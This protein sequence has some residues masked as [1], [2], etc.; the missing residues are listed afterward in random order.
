MTIK[1]PAG[2]V[3][4]QEEQ[5]AYKIPLS[6]TSSKHKESSPPRYATRVDMTGALIDSRDNSIH[7]ESSVGSGGDLVL[8][9]EDEN[10]VLRKSRI[11]AIDEEVNQQPSVKKLYDKNTFKT[12]ANSYAP[13][14][15]KKKLLKNFR[16]WN[17]ENKLVLLWVVLM[18]IFFTMSLY[19]RAQSNRNVA[20]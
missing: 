12:T 20:S 7:D 8:Y 6:K 5:H 13:V 4:H 11:S 3:D 9:Q 14:A 1:I 15:K 19:A 16:F 10:G 17:Y 18:L 2:S